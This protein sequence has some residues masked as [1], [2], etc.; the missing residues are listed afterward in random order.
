MRTS[1]TLSIIL[2]GVIGMVFALVTG[3]VYRELAL[4]NQR[5]ALANM[6]NLKVKDL[7]G[8]L[9]G[10]SRE[11][12]S[13]LLSEPAFRAS[14][15][16]RNHKHV[17]SLLNNQFHRYYQTA[18]IIRLEKLFLF[19]A[20]YSLF[21]ES[22]EGATDIGKF[23]MIC[24]D[25][26]LQARQRKGAENL[27]RISG[28]C[29]SGAH[30][31]QTVVL[32]VGGLRP[33]GYV[34]V[35]T[36]PAHSL[37]P[38]ESALGM[39]LRLVRPDG[40]EVFRSSH[41]P[42]PDAL[43]KVLL[44]EFVLKS[45]AMENALTISM[46]ADLRPLNEK[47]LEARNVVL[48]L[49]GMATL[50]AVFGALVVMQKTAL[51]PLR[52]LMRQIQLVIKDRSNLGV[53]V[54]VTGNSEISELASN[55]N[56]LTGELKDLYE[57]LGTMAFS[58][59]LTKLP[60]RTLFND[61]V[62]QAI[63]ISERQQSSFALFMMDL[64]R[65]KQVN[66]TLGHTVGDKLLQQVAERLQGALRKS[67]TITRMSD[68][69]LA[70]LGGDE[71]A[72]VLPLIESGNYAGLAAKRIQ[73]SMLQPFMIE[74]HSLNVGIS[75]G[76]ALYPSNGTDADTLVRHA[77]VAMYQAKKD[78]RGFVFYD[79]EQD[80]HSVFHLTMES[81]LRSAM[82]QNKLQLYFQPKI[83]IPSGKICSAEALL[84]WIH[85]ERGFV[86]PDEFI[87]IAEQ[88]GLIEPLTQWVLNKALEQCTKWHTAG[89]PISVAV[90]LSARSLHNSNITED[91]ELALANWKVPSS[92][93]CLELTE[94]A[95]M[96]DPEQAMDILTKLNDMGVLLSV[97]DFGTGYS[98]LAYLKK[99]PVNEIKIDKSFVMDMT[100]DS[101]DSAIVHSIVDLA[102]NMS[103]KVVAE[104]V[105]TQEILQHL[106]LMGCDIAQGY[107]FD[108][109]LPPEDFIRKLTGLK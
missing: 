42:A 12:G 67:D 87:P 85:P 91:V 80:R 65:F 40:S 75:I 49:A 97:D 10:K 5:S 54:T 13:D 31:F 93:L 74:N 82:E 107:Y 32:P 63:N 92:G 45:S 96:A 38:L 60:N 76:I 59:P 104:G 18:N 24:G 103:L 53:P 64:D 36:D 3:S 25:L 27:K 48:L 66:D 37:L 88:S 6:I 11:L 56:M 29:L 108:R 81:E 17:I 95:I 106:T 44:A 70:R 51:R 68:E 61:R 23:D 1:L 46:A 84:R 21:A 15:D 9:E 98:S 94:S 14:F 4:D 55:F 79:S 100:R 26:L 77:D 19:D 62:G 83:D 50:L 57:K 41:W 89:F 34:A 47:L 16:S 8:G 73:D 35:V 86:P 28:L 102:H 105:E 101:N 20:N 78:Q 43:D 109:P 7:L 99:L 71:F 72:A 52:S 39:P 30:L 69:T 33:I 22:S 58:D 2:M 90:N